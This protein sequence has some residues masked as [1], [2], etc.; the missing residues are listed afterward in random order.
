MNLFKK[1]FLHSPYLYVI[2]LGISMLITFIYV[3]FNGKTVYMFINGMS[4][5]GLV[6]ILIGG[7]MTT[8]YFGGFNSFNY[9]FGK[10]FKYSKNRNLK[11]YEYNQQQIIKRKAENLFFVPY[12]VIGLLTLLISVILEIIF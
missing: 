4:I 2:S 12:Y 9:S 7:L 5:A 10:I 8:T 1:I 11:F 6:L 3:F